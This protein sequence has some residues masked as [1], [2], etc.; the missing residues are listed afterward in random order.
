MKLWRRHNNN[1]QRSKCFHVLW[2]RRNDNV[3]VNRRT[4]QD[5][6]LTSAISLTFRFL[7][8]RLISLIAYD[9]FFFLRRIDWNLFMKWKKLYIAKNATIIGLK[10]ATIIG[11]KNATIIGLKNAT[12]IGLKNATIIGL[13]NATIIGLKN[14]TIIGLKNATIIGLENVIGKSAFNLKT[15]VHE[16]PLFQSDVYFWFT[17][18]LCSKYLKSIRT[19]GKR[20]QCYRNVNMLKLEAKIRYRWPYGKVHDIEKVRWQEL[21]SVFKCFLTRYSI[22]SISSFLIYAIMRKM[23][24]GSSVRKKEKRFVEHNTAIKTKGFNLY[25]KTK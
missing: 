14:A 21:I 18:Q 9:L 22:W 13:K 17:P 23:L 10:N 11:L 19:S 8:V 5:W 1:G 4:G 15:W 24:K 16:T 25:L 3:Y 6:Y 20:T 12:I 7:I 2:Y